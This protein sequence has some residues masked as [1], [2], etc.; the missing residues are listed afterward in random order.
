MRSIKSRYAEASI[1]NRSKAVVTRLLVSVKSVREATLALGGGA[2]LI[3]AKDP[4]AG[5]LGSLPT[6]VVAAI[7]G[8]VAGRAPTSAVVGVD[9]IDLLLEGAASM[10]RT[11]VSFVK[12]GLS[13]EMTTPDA[14][15]IL[16]RGL[17]PDVAV[18]AVLAAE[19]ASPA[20]L[21]GRLAA[22]GFSGVMIDTRDKVGGRLTDLMAHDDLSRF[23]ASCRAEGV[24]CGLA[25]SLTIGDIA[26]LAPLGADYLGFRGGICF[27]GRRVAALDPERVASAAR[28]LARCSVSPPWR[29]APFEAV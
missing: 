1:A 19:D 9:D 12:L 17:P 25:G 14:L 15:R 2:G 20:H 7:H 27:D 6:E 24:M 8:S 16:G 18:V 22:T 23:V 11:G 3:D 29:S 26:V 21:V 4:A 5:A 28:E 10:A 13:P